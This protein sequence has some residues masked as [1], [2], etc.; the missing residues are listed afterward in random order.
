MPNIVSS[1]I[2]N[3]PPPDALADL[4]NKRNKI[5]H[6]DDKTDEDMIPIFSHDV[7]GKPRN[8]KRLLNRR[9]WC[10]IRVYNP[11][12]SPPPTPASSNHTL[13]NT[14][15]AIATP[16]VT[17]SRSLLRRFSTSKPKSPTYRQD[18]GPPLSSTSFFNRQSQ[19]QSQS[20]EQGQPQPSS[21][22]G[23]TSSQRPSLI[24]RTLSLTRKDFN[25]S[26]L[27]RRSSTSGP[28]R[29]R[30]DDGINGYNSSTDSE[31]EP[32]EVQRTGYS[33]SSPRRSKPA[34][35]SNARTR[36]PAQYQDEDD[37][38]EDE[39]QY[40]R[41]QPVRS[42]IR[43][44]GADSPGVDSDGYFPGTST[45]PT[46][47]NSRAVANQKRSSSISG[48]ADFNADPNPNARSGQDM[49]V[50]PPRRAFHRTPTSLSSKQ[51]PHTVNLEGGLDITL[52]VEV[53]PRD[54]AGITM[55]YRLLVPRLWYVGQGDEVK[56]MRGGMRRWAGFVRGGRGRWRDHHQVEEA[57]SGGDGGG[58]SGGEAEV[59]GGG[60]RWSGGVRGL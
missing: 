20:Q 18:A 21:R 8:N 22:R 3:T 46:H 40:A 25:P 27:F 31:T 13:T 49:N 16:P 34:P 12:L 29:R 42:G 1:A 44:G 39:A 47:N 38:T 57:E 36:G 19:A 23:S 43:G 7:T 53:S 14:N 58:R 50:P 15:T 41:R 54:P 59:E 48:D 33:N 52:N 45:Y 26:S 60:R 56:N 5:H 35:N 4:L 51:A 24:T 55:P 28:R 37:S 17:R 10:A 30:R 9:N 6:L 32:E 2:A 11:D